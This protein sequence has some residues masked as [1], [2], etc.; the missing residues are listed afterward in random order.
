MEWVF[1]VRPEDRTRREDGGLGVFHC[2]EWLPMFR[3][4]FTAVWQQSHENTCGGGY[5]GGEG[6]SGVWY[7]S[8]SKRV[9]GMRSAG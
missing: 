4:C 2:E 8:V 5:L 9:G 6:V 1:S 7:A 3:S